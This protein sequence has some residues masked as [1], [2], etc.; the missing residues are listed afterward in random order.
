ML[1]L[2]AE[3]TLSY[4]GGDVRTPWK[5]IPLKVAD[6]LVYVFDRTGIGHGRLDALLEG[7]MFA[8][9]APDAETYPTLGGLRV[10]PPCLLRASMSCAVA[11]KASMN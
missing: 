1:G 9:D 8:V 4:I 7:Q 3:E 11:A 10:V 5:V 6:A 2:D